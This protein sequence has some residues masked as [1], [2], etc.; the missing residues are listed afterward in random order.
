[1]QQ[2]AFL[3]NQIYAILYVIFESE[4]LK[5]EEYEIFTTLSFTDMVIAVIF[6]LVS[7]TCSIPLL[8]RAA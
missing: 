4:A 2:K 7:A 6:W 8:V 1:M 5:G 3:D